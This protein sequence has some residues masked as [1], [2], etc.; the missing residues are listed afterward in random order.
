M[1]KKFQKAQVNF[2]KEQF[3]KQDNLTNILQMLFY[4]FE[5]H[6][7]MKQSNFSNKSSK[8]IKKQK[9][10]IAWEHLKH[11]DWLKKKNISG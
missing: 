11:R 1:E 8:I 9:L 6:I 5:L 3:R 10:Q 4:V 2:Q 7:P